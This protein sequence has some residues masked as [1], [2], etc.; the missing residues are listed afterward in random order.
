MDEIKTMVKE[1]FVQNRVY[2]PQFSK[3]D[4]G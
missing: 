4:V 1:M 3:I 2:L